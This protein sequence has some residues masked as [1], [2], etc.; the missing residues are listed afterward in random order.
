MWAIAIAIVAALALGLGEGITRLA[1]VRT[2]AIKIA[3]GEYVG[4]A[5]PDPAL[6]WRNNPGVHPADEGPHEVMTILPDGSRLSGAPG[7]GATVLI[8][9]CS[10]AEGYGVRD[11]EAFAARLQQQFPQLRMRN[12]AVPGY[13]TYQSL[14]TLRDLIER[15]GVRPALV[16]YGF[17]PFH[18]ERNVLTYSMLEAFRAFGGE[19]FSPPHVELS[20][21]GLRA[22]PPFVVHD[23]PLEERSALVT[24]LHRSELRLRLAGREAQEVQ[25]TDMLLA[26]MK[27]LVEAAQARLLV[28]TLW[29]G[30]SPS[31]PKISADMRKAGIEQLDV[32]YKGEEKRPEKILVG[33]NGHPGAIIH[34][35]WAD[36]LA[37]WM[38][39]QGYGR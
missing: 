7:A 31:Y 10:Y 39:E 6:G 36:R 16:I 30:G 21:G 22:Y 24:L 18:A 17:L 14:L 15:Q 26:Q 25:V 37:R 20:A 4:W 3:G 9:G 13:G 12:F 29:D 11:D 5:K 32:T 27:T 2:F 34:A 1:G 19:R 33:G 38:A 8:V 23:W 35:W 28:A